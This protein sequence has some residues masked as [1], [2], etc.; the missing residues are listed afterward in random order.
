MITGAKDSDRRNLRAKLTRSSSNYDTLAL[1][2]PRQLPRDNVSLPRHFSILLELKRDLD[3]G[4]APVAERGTA[5]RGIDLDGPA[6][7]DASHV[8]YFLDDLVFA[9]FASHAVISLQIVNCCKG[10]D[11]SQRMAFLRSPDSWICRRKA[12]TAATILLRSS[13]RG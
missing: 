10:R 8:T 7:A 4:P 3:L 9:V 1:G 2:C 5:P 13:P 6:R 12:P 11:P